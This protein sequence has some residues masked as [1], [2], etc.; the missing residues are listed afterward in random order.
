MTL[1]MT[2]SIQMV[3]LKSRNT[4]EHITFQKLA[5]SLKFFY[6]FLFSQTINYS[7][8]SGDI[9]TWKAVSALP[10]W[11]LVLLAVLRRNSLSKFPYCF[12]LLLK[13]S[14][15]H[16]RYVVAWTGK[17][18]GE[19]HGSV[20]CLWHIPPY[21]LPYLWSV[22]PLLKSLSLHTSLTRLCSIKS[23][24]LHA[25]TL[26]LLFACRTSLFKNTWHT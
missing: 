4:L 21:S 25:M 3:S 16:G 19:N 11:N 22:V 6:A 18:V 24:D 5:Q 14:L 7:H 17:W 13:C 23:W 2:E 20:Q 10:Y 12:H 1:E 8:Y 15:G 26:F 9:T